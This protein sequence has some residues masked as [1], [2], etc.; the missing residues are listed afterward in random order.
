[1]ENAT[2]ALLIAGGILISILVITLLANLFGTTG[3]VVESY[4][5]EIN[6]TE[7][8]K[9]NANFMQYLSKQLTIYDVVTIC[10][11]AH[12]NNTHPINS[13]LITNG[14]SVND[15]QENIEKKFKLSIVNF[16]ENGYVNQIAFTEVTT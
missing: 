10:N 1:M 12:N 4:N 3:N 14:K 11:F 8:E 6:I 7:I 15:I 13:S 2:K 5:K 16:D 9:F